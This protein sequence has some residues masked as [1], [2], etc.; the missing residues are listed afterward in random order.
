MA[1]IL[2]DNY[3]FPENLLGMQETI[4]QAISSGEILHISDSKTLAAVLTSGVQ[5]A[6][7]DPRL[8]VSYEPNYVPV[9][10]PALPTLPTEQLRRL[11]RNTI[12]LELLE[13]NVGYLRIDRIIGQETA[14]KL[15]H[16]LHENIWNKL[17]HTSAM[18]FD[19]RFSTSGALSGVPYIISYFSDPDP[20]ILIDTI[21]DRPTNTTKEVWTMPNIIGDR[22]GPKKDLIVLISKRTTG[23]AESVAYILK[24]LQRAIIVGER[25][26]GG[27][28]KVGKVKI[29]DSDFYVMVPTARST[30]PITGQSWEV[31][32]VSPSVPVTTREAVTKAKALL[33]ARKAFP[34]AVKRVS[35]IIRRFY[36]SREKIEALLN[37]LAI[38]NFLTVLSE[39]GLAA[40]LNYELQTVSED[41]RLSVK[42]M[43]EVPVVAEDNPNVDAIPGGAL[44][45]VEILSGNTG[46]IRCDRFPKLSAFVRVAKEVWENVEGTEN[47]IIDLRYNTGGSSKVLPMLLS[48]LYDTSSNPIRLYTIYDRIQNVTTDYHTYS[49]LTSA[50]YG[51]KKGVYVLTSYYTAAAG[52]EFAYLIQSLHR[53]TVIGEITS[54][55][56]LHSRSFRVGDT[57]IVVTVPVL[58]FIDNIGECWLG[59]G[60]VPDAI[61]LAEDAINQAHDIINFHKHIQPFVKQAAILLETYYAF[62]E[63]ASKVGRVLQSKLDEGIYR[64]VIDFESL[65]SQLS[66]DLQETSGD[67]RLH[68]FYC[69]IEPESQHKLPKIP[70]PEEMGYIIDTLFKVEVLDVNVG[71]LRFDMMADIEVVRAMGLTLITKVWNKLVNTDVMIMDVRFNT[72][73]YATAIPLLCSYFFEAEHLQHMYSISDRATRT[74]TDV[75]TLPEVLGQRYGS[76]KDIYILTSQM[77]GSAAEAFTQTMKDLK[78][79][80]VIGEPTVGGSLSSGTYQL[81]DSILYASIPTQ[82]VLSA[83]SGKEWSISGVEPHVSVQ[84]SDALNVTL[85]IIAERQQKLE[86]GD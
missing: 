29:R 84:A 33:S 46:Y 10:P 73:G 23:A 2:L 41:P 11:I 9:T 24:H 43:Q 42:I 60:V 37:Q 77:T 36:S 3:C 72:G 76:K 71:Y 4:Q 86:S 59:G 49:N 27:S 48:Y 18:I 85:K 53:G 63:V 56:L 75:T 19:L 34:K 78:R 17:I 22:Y 1:K 16:L 82:V 15:G 81:G 57:S 52:E 50:S 21:Y 67:H 7:N 61:V 38:T 20:L 28:V 44:F 32:G 45:D 79:A 6:L 30:N 69:E 65:A 55:T 80:T 83:V 66:V 14:A 13:N 5:S 12:K 64:S 25:S 40:K 62:P 35:D 39:E 68:I 54:G 8:T 74:R 51:S 58:N 47:L 26:A 70:S 31:R